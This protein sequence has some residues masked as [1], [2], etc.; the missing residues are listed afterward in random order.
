MCSCWSLCVSLSTRPT[1]RFL[2][3]TR[4]FSWFRSFC[5]S[6][7]PQLVGRGSRAVT[8]PGARFYAKRTKNGKNADVP[9]GAFTD[10]FSPFIVFDFTT[11][12]WWV[13]RSF[14]VF[15]WATISL[16]PYFFL[17]WMFQFIEFIYKGFLNERWVDE[18]FS[19]TFIMFPSPC[20][21]STSMYCIH[22]YVLKTICK[23]TTDGCLER[24]RVSL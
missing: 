10:L 5:S 3:E 14:D 2:K 22:E 15:I 9:G 4:A 17:P 6:T 21:S 20:H 8:T 1:L 18:V 11:S 19:I 7:S 16:C 12:V 23:F 24:S 13:L